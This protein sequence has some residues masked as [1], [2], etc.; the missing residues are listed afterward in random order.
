MKR[1]WLADLSIVLFSILLTIFA[2]ELAIRWMKPQNMALV[3]PYVE[4]HPDYIFKVKSRLSARHR[5]FNFDARYF[6]DDRGLRVAR[7]GED[8][9]RPSLDERK[10]SRPLTRILCIGDSVTFG[11]GVNAGQAFP[12]QLE[13]F[14]S[15]AH[16]ERRWQ[17]LNA[18]QPGWGTSQELLWLEKEG[19]ALKP[20]L[21]LLGFTLN[22][23]HDDWTNG[24]MKT[25]KGVLVRNAQGRPLETGL[26]R[27]TQ[28]VPFYPLLCENSYLLTLSRKFVTVTLQKW[29]KRRRDS[30]RPGS[31]AQSGLDERRETLL[32][33]ELSGKI[34]ETLVREARARGVSVAIAFSPWP[35]GTANLTQAED[36]HAIAKDTFKPLKVPILDMNQ[37]LIK[38]ARENGYG[39]PDV[40]LVGDGHMTPLGNR[41]AAEYLARNL[42]FPT[43]KHPKN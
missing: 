10:E 24:L 43:Q 14:L 33:F 20:D 6:T 3:S 42:D 12:A 19:F 16:P 5:S 41:I 40:Y 13:A 37:Q 26:R 32:K 11:I 36:P 30:E 34:M 38:V 1:R 15:E 4:Q 18:G 39:Y 9:L 2:A 22:D 25:E 27:I 29:G 31:A 8:A 21:I 23:P 28:K 35:I 7:K 17:V